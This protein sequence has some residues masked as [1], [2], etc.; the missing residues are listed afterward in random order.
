MND[1]NDEATQLI[2]ESTMTTSIVDAE[3]TPELHA[4]LL[5]L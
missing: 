3:Y 4:E 5:R 1:T 2:E